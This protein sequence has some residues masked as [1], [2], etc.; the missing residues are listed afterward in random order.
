MSSINSAT[1]AKSKNYKNLELDLDFDDEF[2]LHNKAAE[3]GAFN[4][5]KMH[6]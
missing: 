5:I 1:P 4:E 2:N 3:T 6:G